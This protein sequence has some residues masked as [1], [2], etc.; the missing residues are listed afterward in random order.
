MDV[1]LDFAERITVLHFGQVVVEGTRSE[2]VA[3]P[4]DAGDLPW[5]V[6]RWCST[7]STRSTATATCCTGMSLRL[8]EGRLLGLLGR[9]GAGK[10]TSMSVTV[11]PAAA[12]A[13]HAS[14]SSAGP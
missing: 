2:V 14:R 8:G 11:G 12:P 5:R 13:R 3:H 1:A 9:N 10:S 4:A 6:T 7:T